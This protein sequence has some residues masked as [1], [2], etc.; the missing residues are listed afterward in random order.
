MPTTMPVK[1]NQRCSDALRGDCFVKCAPTPTPGQANT[2]E[3]VMDVI[4]DL[5][6][7][8][9]SASVLAGQRS[10]PCWPVTLHGDA[11]LTVCL[12]FALTA[13][14]L[15]FALTAETTRSALRKTMMIKTWGFMSAGLAIPRR[16]GNGN[17]CFT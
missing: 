5:S 17:F 6:L 13:E 14:C 12:A 15:V 1:A 3:G 8:T 4:F 7:G 11:S 16:K 9:L 2:C 10:T